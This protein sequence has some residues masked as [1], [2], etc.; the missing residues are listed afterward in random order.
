M[1]FSS[2]LCFF[3]GLLPALSSL[4]TLIENWTLMK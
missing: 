3:S 4:Q 2:V 1:D